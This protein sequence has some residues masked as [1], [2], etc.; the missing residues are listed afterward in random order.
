MLMANGKGSARAGS[1]KLITIYPVDEVEL[2]KVLTGLGSGWP[3]SLDRT[4]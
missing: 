3:G 2:E 4:F 1:G